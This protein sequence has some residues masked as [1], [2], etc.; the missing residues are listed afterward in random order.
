M[1]H[2]NLIDKAFLLKKTTLFGS[3]DL[4]LLL[5]IADKM[6]ALNYKPTDK[7]FQLDQDAT[8]MYVIISGQIAIEDKGGIQLAELLPGDFF[9]DEALFN[10]KRR[11]YIALCNTKVELLA[12][13]RSHLLS[14]LQECPS[15]AIALLES[16]SAPLSFRPR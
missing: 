4:D 11:S 13:S 3:L 14:I 7:V 8:R 6:E 9:G 5:S 12:L 10:E 15:V 1:R 16:Y 2:F